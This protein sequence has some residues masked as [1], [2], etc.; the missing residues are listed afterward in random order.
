M[1]KEFAIIHVMCLSFGLTASS[2]SAGGQ[3]LKDDDVKKL[4]EEAKKDVERFT[5]AVDS[6]YRT[7]KI[8]TAASEVAVDGYLKDLKKSAEAMRDRFKEDYAASR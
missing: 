6:K 4:M 5:G 2:A 3:R 1:L 7:A 8:R